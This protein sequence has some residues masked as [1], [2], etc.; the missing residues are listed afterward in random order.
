MTLRTLATHWGELIARHRLLTIGIWIFILVACG[1]LAPLLE[2]R[3]SAPNLSTD[4]SESAR[5]NQTMKAHFSHQGDEQD[6]IVFQS[7]LWTV[8][9]PPFKEVVTRAIAIAKENSVVLTVVSPYSAVA[10]QQISDDRRT[11]IAV[12][13]VRGNPIALKNAADSLQREIQNAGTDSITAELTG[14]SPFIRDVSKLG[15]SDAGRA[16]SISIPLALLLLILATGSIAAATIP[17]LS[18]LTGLLASFGILYL[19]S[20]TTS[21]DTN[22]VAVATM[23]GTGV[24]I[25]YSLF[26]VSRFREELSK[27]PLQTHLTQESIAKAIGI[28]ISTAGK[29]I[30][31][32]GLIV[33][34]SLATVVV[35]PAP[36]FREISIGVTVTVG[37]A[38]IISL[39][40]LPAVLAVVGTRVNWGSLP[41]RWQ[42]AGVARRAEGTTRWANWARTVMARPALSA[43]LVSTLLVLCSA[44][45]ASIQYG[46]NLGTEATAATPAGH[47]LNVLA[48]KYSPGLL[49]PIHII[50]TGI[51]DTPLSAEAMTTTNRFVDALSRNTGI[52]QVRSEARDGRVLVTVIP[53]TRVDSPG[54]AALVHKLRAM[55]EEYHASNGPR[56]RVGGVTAE[57][58]D[59]SQLIKKKTPL[60]VTLVL[61]LSFLFLLLLFR[62]VA[63]STKAIVMN[64]LSTGAALGITVA[65][66]QWGYGQSILN[67]TSTG[68]LQ[69]YLPLA[70]FCIIFGLSMDYEVFLIR[71]IKEHWEQLR[72]NTESVAFGIEHTARPIT[73]AAAIMVAIFSSFLTAD[74]L[75]LKQFGL[76][77]SVAVAL[78]AL[79]VRLILV[80]ALMQLLGKWNWWL[81]FQNRNNEIVTSTKDRH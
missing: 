45:V 72:D 39:T 17:L 63:L 5:A 36:I 64:L 37:T 25:D 49:A 38:V 44:P 28:A 81:P 75:E 41:D 66:F 26:I 73:T 9:D 15:I 19:L 70:V 13:S 61:G 29:T 32:S 60:V 31:A 55:A 57:F 59:L 47:A 50:S 76:A 77:L 54:A 35:V 12:L 1:T 22:I 33:L 18:A 2:G 14:F 43:L 48:D 6:V 69:V 79:L 24:G 65:V 30:A 68:F 74:I 20:F 80:P 58:I 21:F 27:R 71:R 46:V 42:P 62:S 56:L 78:D 16:E 4:H 8:D 11:A 3:L 10:N 67:F 52:S 7:K 34:V 53:A 51:G 40:L 23:L